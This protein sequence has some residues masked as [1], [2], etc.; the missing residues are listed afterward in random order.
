MCIRDSR[1]C[2]WFVN[3]S[4]FLIEKAVTSYPGTAV[5]DIRKASSR[6]GL[7]VETLNDKQ[8]LR[9]LK[10]QKVGDIEVEVVLHT[11]LN[12]SKRVVVF[13]LLQTR[14]EE[15]I[16]TELASQ[17]LIACRRLTVQRYGRTPPAVP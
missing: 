4:P 15:E 8:V 5:K 9:L 7:L 17:G 11:T 2:I 1:Q 14:S 3:V 12:T 10:L 6:L 16:A 13:R